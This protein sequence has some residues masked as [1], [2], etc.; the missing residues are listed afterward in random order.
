MIYSHVTINVLRG[1][2]ISSFPALRQVHSCHSG[3]HEEAKI[4]KLGSWLLSE[5]VSLKLGS[6]CLGHL[7]EQLCPQLVLEVLG[8]DCMRSI[9]ERDLKEEKPKAANTLE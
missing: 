9:Q 8:E 7:R 6:V 1:L 2:S 3:L 4:E 5:G